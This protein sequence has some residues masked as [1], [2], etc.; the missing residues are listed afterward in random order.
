MT[1]Y[2]MDRTPVSHERERRGSGASPTAP[3]GVA[4]PPLQHRQLAAFPLRVAERLRSAVV[5][6]APVDGRQHARL[7]MAERLERGDQLGAGEIFAGPL[8]RLG[9][10]D[11]GCAAE[12]GMICGVGLVLDF[13]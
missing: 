13:C 5:G 4:S 10:D 12:V 1:W 2:D 11:A 7:E 9:D 3:R 8:H 6:R